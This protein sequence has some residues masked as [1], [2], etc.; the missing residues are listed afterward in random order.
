MAA[1]DQQSPRIAPPS[2]VDEAD[3]AEPLKQA[4]PPPID[5]AAAAERTALKI[6]R[7]AIIACGV[8]PTQGVALLA[9]ADSFARA[10]ARRLMAEG[11][12]S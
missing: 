10:R 6:L 12:A 3:L 2:T 8:P 4:P 5:T 1:A 11:G 9:A 7:D